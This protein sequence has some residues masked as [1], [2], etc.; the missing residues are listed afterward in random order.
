M[1]LLYW[2]THANYTQQILLD[3]IDIRNFTIRAR[4]LEIWYPQIKK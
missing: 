4:E 1:Y 2:E 3:V